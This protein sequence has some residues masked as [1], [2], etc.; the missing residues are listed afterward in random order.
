MK[1]VNGPVQNRLG[2]HW[3]EWVRG[4]QTREQ[5][6]QELADLSGPQATLV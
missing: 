1:V 6:Q 5:I 3:F 4:Q 2:E